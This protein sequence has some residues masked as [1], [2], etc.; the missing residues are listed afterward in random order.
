MT[1][2]SISLSDGER[3]A[4]LK[5]AT[6][7]HMSESAYI[8]RAVERGIAGELDAQRPLTLPGKRTRVS[9]RL[10]TL[11]EEIDA[12]RGAYARMTWVRDMTLR[13]LAIDMVPPTAG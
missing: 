13:A 7:A 9:C 3:R 5:C 8:R 11:R 4:L 6:S 10:P 12:R 2:S 1:P